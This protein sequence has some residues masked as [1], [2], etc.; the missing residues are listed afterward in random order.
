MAFLPPTFILWP[1]KFP[2]SCLGA[3]SHLTIVVLKEYFRR[4][5]SSLPPGTYCDV[6]GGGVRSN[7]SPSNVA[8]ESGV[9]CVVSV[10]GWQCGGRQGEVR[11][12]RVSLAVPAASAL[13]FYPATKANFSICPTCKRTVI[14]VSGAGTTNGQSVFIQ[15]SA[16]KSWSW[17]LT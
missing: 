13:V 3:V 14:V 7:V 5:N 1:P 12:G 8:V 15:G 2:R 4:L 9:G 17:T 11:G 6:I 10:E 16:W